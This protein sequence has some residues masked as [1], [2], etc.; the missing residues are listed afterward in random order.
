LQPEKYDLFVQKDVMLPARDGVRLATDIYLPATQGTLAQGPFPAILFRTPYDKNML[1]E[2]PLYADFFVPRGYVVVC[3]DVRGLH[4]SEGEFGFLP[5]E[6]PDGADTVEW[7]GNQ[8]WCNGKVGTIGCS[9]RAWVQSAL[10]LERPAPLAAMIV[11]EGGSNAHSNTIRNGGALEMR[12]LCWPFWNL[13]AGHPD[14]DAAELL[15]RTRIRD[16]VEKGGF[17]PGKTPLAH[18]PVQEDFFWQMYTRGTFD[19][20]WD[21]PGFEFLSRIQD[22]AD[23]PTLVI[24]GWYDSYARAAPE[25]YEALRKTKES[26]IR[27][28]MGPWVHGTLNPDESFAGGLEFG[29]SA[30]LGFLE[31][32]LAWFDRHLKGRGAAGPPVR[33]FRMGGGNG[34]PDEEGRIRHGGEWRE[35]TRWPP[36]EMSVRKL[37]LKEGG[38]LS[39]RP[40]KTPESATRFTFDPT[41]P[42]PTIGGCISSLDER[43]P[44]ATDNPLRPAHRREMAHLAPQGGWDQREREGWIGCAHPGRPLSERPDVCVFQ[45]DPLEEVMEVTGPVRVALW[46]STSAPDTDFTAKLLDV[47]PDGRA[48]NLCDGIRRLRFA[49]DPRKEVFAKP[50]K[51]VEVTIDL[52]TTSN[53]FLKGHRIRLD[54]SSSNFPRFDVNPNTG[55]PLWRHTSTQVA[56]NTVH[57]S[58]DYPSRLDLPVVAPGKAST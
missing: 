41:D 58:G 52:Y 20:F 18:M 10:A 12:W 30:G 51:I 2:G 24:S 49:K 11:H 56:K 15:N 53:L 42:V 6:G 3:Q 19:E 32:A 43:R 27:L 50:G 40:S 55:E 14:R 38:G 31:T 29:P 1:E 8:T 25:M 13:P 17:A 54:V 47:Y 7:I 26:E 46:V 48:I 9:Y 34:S 44:P 39:N 23:V 16:L 21:R 4:R 35:S 57:H 5:Q 22:H 36:K 37:Y 45:T 33:F 28:I